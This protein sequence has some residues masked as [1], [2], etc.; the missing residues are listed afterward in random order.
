MKCQHQYEQRQKELYLR[1]QQVVDRRLSNS[2]LVIDLTTEDDDLH[3]ENIK[4]TS[5]KTKSDANNENKEVKE[6]SP[7][8]KKKIRKKMMK[9]KIG[10]SILIN[11]FKS[12]RLVN[13]SSKYRTKEKRTN[14]S[15]RDSTKRKKSNPSSPST[16]GQKVNAIRWYA[17][18]RHTKDTS[19]KSLVESILLDEKDKRLVQV[20]QEREE[21]QIALQDVRGEK[22]VVEAKLKEVEKEKIAAETTLKILR[23]EKQRVED[24]KELALE[25]KICLDVREERY[26]LVPCGHIMCSVCKERY[27]ACPT[28]SRHVNSQLRVHL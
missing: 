28:C 19:E 26:A 6:I 5:M 20:K 21:T 3:D 18:K 22:E 12:K 1:L 4:D 25:C 11:L 13:P 27:S 23:E 8:K 9:K 7:T 2:K 17:P 16:K 24:E 10:R 14:P 15:P